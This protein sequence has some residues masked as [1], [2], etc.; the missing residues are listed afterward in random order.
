MLLLLFAVDEL[1]PSG[2]VGCRITPKWRIDGQLSIARLIGEDDSTRREVRTVRDRVDEAD[3]VALLYPIACSSS[4][5]RDDEFPGSFLD[6]S[7]IALN[8]ASRAFIVSYFA[9]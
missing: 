5:R 1:M 8:T 2:K 9:F 3:F 7:W 6:P 4:A